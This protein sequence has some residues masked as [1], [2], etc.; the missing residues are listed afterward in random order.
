MSLL[1]AGAVSSALTKLHTDLVSASH[2]LLKPPAV[3]R[4]AVGHLLVG[5]DNEI[6]KVDIR[7]HGP[8]LQ[9]QSLD[10]CHCEGVQVLKKVWVVDLTWLPDALRR[11]R[12]RE[13]TIRRSS[14]DN[15]A[16]HHHIYIFFFS[17]D[18]CSYLIV[19]VVHQRGFPLAFVLRVVD[20]RTFPFS[21]TRG[22]L[23]G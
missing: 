13:G 21:T 12:R 10:S 3:R 14:A 8:Q 15:D 6:I 19:R 2:Q 1:C 16:M 20:H 18:F 17:G 23:T 11:R 4:P 9:A 22:R 5:G 7:G